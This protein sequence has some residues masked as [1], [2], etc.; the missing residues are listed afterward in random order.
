[1]LATEPFFTTLLR[2]TDLVAAEAA[3]ADVVAVAEGVFP[4]PGLLYTKRPCAEVIGQE[5]RRLGDSLRGLPLSIR[6]FALRIKHTLRRK[7]APE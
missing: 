6:V 4:V 3:A 1:M 7:P 5:R 2:T